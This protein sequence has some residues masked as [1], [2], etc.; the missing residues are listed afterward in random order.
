LI[1]L[2]EVLL[3]LTRDL[4]QIAVDF[5]IIG[6]VAMGAR[7]EPRFTRD[8]DIA[9]A[10]RDDTEAEAVVR[11]LFQR[12]YR[13][14]AVI[15]QTVAHR[16]ATV[17]L[18]PPLDDEPPIVDLLF[19][20]SGIENEVVEAAEPAEVFPGVTAKV[21]TVSSLLAMK[22]LC[23]NDD[24]RPQDRIDLAE[25]L[26]IATDADRRAASKLLDLI[27]ERGFN[28]DRD[29]RKAFNEVCEEFGRAR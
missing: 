4:Q 19:A 29:L 11:H 28:R 8:L 20:S 16:M 14:L 1:S 7:T 9:L 18:L 6:G 17:R 26:K 5:A 23:R 12:G 2:R 15:E 13:T 3:Q 24:E 22:V 10:A 27:I 21:A 25:L